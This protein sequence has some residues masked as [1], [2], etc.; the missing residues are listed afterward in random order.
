MVQGRHLQL[1]CS[2]YMYVFLLPPLPCQDG[3]VDYSRELHQLQVEG[4]MPM[5]DLLASL[6]PEFLQTGPSQEEGGEAMDVREEEGQK[7]KGVTKPKPHV[8][9]VPG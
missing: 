4:E 8:Y 7:K 5:E 3:P 9:V 1:L 6:P 2:V